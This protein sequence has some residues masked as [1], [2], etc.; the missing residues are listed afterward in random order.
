MQLRWTRDAAADLEHIAEYL[1]Q[2]VPER[3]SALVRTVYE[4]PALLLEFPH[5]GRPGTKAGTRA[6]V[7]PSL[8]YVI[9]YMVRADVV[10][11]VRILHGAQQWP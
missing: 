3:A 1:V 10:F 2:H 8:P 5:R 4:A 9:V 11:V 7:M 6:L